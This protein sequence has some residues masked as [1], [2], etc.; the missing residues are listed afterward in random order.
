MEDIFIITK[1]TCLIFGLAGIVISQIE[2]IK[3][4]I[5]TKRMRK[6]DSFDLM[7][8]VDYKRMARAHRNE[9]F[10]VLSLAICLIFVSL[11]GTK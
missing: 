8:R 10:S 1:I 3:Y 9:F 11:L 2:L 5:A 4:L 6:P 7:S